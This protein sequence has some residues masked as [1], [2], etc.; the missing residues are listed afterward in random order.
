MRIEKLWQD[1]EKAIMEASK[2][3]IIGYSFP[4]TDTKALNLLKASL[5]KRQGEIDVL[6]V[7]PYADSIKP[8]I[9]NALANHAKSLTTLPIK[10]ED[11]I[12]NLWGTAPELTKQAMNQSEN[13]KNWVTRTFLLSKGFPHDSKSNEATE[14]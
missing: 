7:D 4:S 9:E 12:S 2:I 14:Q 5:E 10:F 13:F 3:T 8:R 11:Y 6:V 1:A